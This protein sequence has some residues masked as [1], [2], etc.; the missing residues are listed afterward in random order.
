MQTKGKT[1]TQQQVGHGPPFQD[2]V[3]DK[4]CFFYKV[5]GLS[6]QCPLR[7]QPFLH[8]EKP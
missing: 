8:E 3:L 2:Y 5:D 7:P 6:E 1:G 4:F